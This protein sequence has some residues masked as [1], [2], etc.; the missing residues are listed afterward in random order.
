MIT[1]GTIG[2]YQ[3]RVREMGNSHQ[4]WPKICNPKNIQIAKPNSECYLQLGS[5]QWWITIH[6][7]FDNKDD[8]I[9][10]CDPE[11][12]IKSYN[13]NHDQSLIPSICGW[14]SAKTYNKEKSEQK[15]K[16]YS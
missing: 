2:A 4:K 8:D 7:S 11:Y 12:R 10:C 1:A 3:S 14:L 15:K 5:K 16:K 9:S 13:H 6:G